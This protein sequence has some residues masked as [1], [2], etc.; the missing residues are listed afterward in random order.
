[1]P[2]TVREISRI[3]EALYPTDIAENWDNVGLQIGSMTGPVKSIMITLEADREIVTEAIRQHIDL[4]ITH[5]PLFFKPLKTINFDHP[6]G[7]LIKNLIRHNIHLYSAHTNLD[8]GSAGLNQYLAEQLELQQIRLLNRSYSETLYKLV[9]YVPADHEAQVRESITAAGAG[10]I[11]QYS[12]CTYRV[13]GTGTFLPGEGSQPFIGTPGQMEEVREYRLETIVPKNLL[14]KVLD[15]MKQSHPY[16]EVAYDVYPLANQGTTYSPG[17]MGV[18]SRSMTLGDFCQHVKQ[19]L[20]VDTL[21]IVGEAED[22]VQKVALVSGSGA[23]FIDQAHRQGCDVLLTGDLKYH[24]AKD[25]Q[26]LGLKI[27]DA[28]HQQMERL[29]APLLAGQL[30]AACREKGCEITIVTCF[31][32]ECIQTI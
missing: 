24:E 19:K 25:A 17:R 8:A 6:Q 11:G 1:M 7:E 16:E 9:V 14:G 3:M 20:A 15:S 28:G 29:M 32:R 5:H 4:I 10:H 26:A 30:R 22:T 21:R 2:V 13:A 31:S 23:G 12:H 27:I 18:L